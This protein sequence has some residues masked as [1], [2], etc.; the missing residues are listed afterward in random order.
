MRRHN[1]SYPCYFREYPR[2]NLVKYRLAECRY[3]STY[4]VLHRI[5]Q[6][7]V[8]A[9]DLLE[10]MKDAIETVVE[11]YRDVHYAHLRSSATSIH[12]IGAARFRARSF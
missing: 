6:H 4:Q 1:C 12:G 2:Q 5:R 11:Y 3:I 7:I 9:R 8:Q 10:L